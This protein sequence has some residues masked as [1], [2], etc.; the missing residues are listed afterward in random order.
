MNVLPIIA[1]RRPNVNPGLNEN[2]KLENADQT[3]RQ[4]VNMIPQIGNS[5]VGNMNVN[6]LKR[7]SHDLEPPH[8][9]PGNE[10][11]QEELPGTADRFAD[12]SDETSN[13]IARPTI[14]LAA[15]VDKASVAVSQFGINIMKVRNDSRAKLYILDYIVYTSFDRIQQ[16]KI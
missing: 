8:Y 14:P 10:K 7:P 6:P 5:N 1:P 12:V 16:I 13:N 9:S 2:Q 4:P 15:P 3:L 11:P